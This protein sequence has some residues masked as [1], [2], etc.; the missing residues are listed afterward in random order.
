M[1]SSAVE[2]GGQDPGTFEA[3]AARTLL[4]QK[5]RFVTTVLQRFLGNQHG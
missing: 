4:D 3:E 5:K 2:P 1:S